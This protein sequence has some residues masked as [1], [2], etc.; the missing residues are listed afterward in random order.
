MKTTVGLFVVGLLVLLVLPSTSLDSAS[1][2][3]R[4]GKEEM[5]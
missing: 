4:T 2:G 3:R 1:L 5:T